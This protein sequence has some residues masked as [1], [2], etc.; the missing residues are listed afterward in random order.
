MSCNDTC[1]EVYTILG[2]TSILVT[3]TCCICCL[4]CDMAIRC[5]LSLLAA[6]QRERQ[7]GV[8]VP[9]VTAAA[10][11]T[12]AAEEPQPVIVIITSPLTHPFR[13]KREEGGI[14]EDPC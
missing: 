7:I 1:A 5:R 14:E 12:A 3:M 8:P 10:A 6:D 2:A 13:T 9:A 4:V 11:A